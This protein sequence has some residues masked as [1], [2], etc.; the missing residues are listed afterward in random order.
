[1][2]IVLTSSDTED[3]PSAVLTTCGAVA[4]VPKTELATSDLEALF[5]GA[6]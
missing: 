2:T 5:A 1:V 3:V 6:A 4:F